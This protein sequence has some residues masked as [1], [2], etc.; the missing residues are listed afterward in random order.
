MDINTCYEAGKDFYSI[1]TYSHLVPIAI[2]LFLSIYILFKTKFS[3]QSI[4]FSLFSGF[5]CLW[6]AGDLITWTSTNY[7]LLVASWSQLD[8]INIIFFVLAA[9]FFVVTI[10]ERDVSIRHKIFLFLLTLPGFYST[11]LLQTAQNFDQAFCNVTNSNFLTQYKLIQEF[12]CIAYIIFIGYLEFVKD[13]ND[14]TKRS[15]IFYIGSAFSLFLG[16]FAVTEYLASEYGGIAYT[17][18]LYG[19]FIL[20]L[21]LLIVIFSIVR[22]QMFDLK[23]IG[24]QLLVYVLVIIVAT[25]FL[26]LEN[27]TNKIL[28]SITLFLAVSFAYMLIKSINQERNYLTQIEKLA[29]DLQIANDGQT[30]LIH[31][32]NHQIKGY[33][34]KSRN[35]FS[36]LLT[37]PLYGPVS[38]AAK[39]MMKEG[40]NSL[41]E[42]VDFVQQILNAS[43][44][45]KGTM[46]YFMQPFDMKKV[47]EEVTEKQRPL[48]EA[49]GLHFETIIDEGNFEINGDRAQLKEAVRNLIDNSI[50]YTIKGSVSVHLTNGAGKILLTVKDTGI[51]I[52]DEDK[53]RLF[54]KGGRGKNSIKINVNSSGYGLSFVKGVI[55][56][57]KGK[58]WCESDGQE[59]GSTFYAELPL[60]S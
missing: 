8:N 21:F 10:R 31:V 40:F 18:S 22:F 43:N 44:I 32:I 19:L 49:K 52:T 56:A 27:S 51:G 4:V 17:V 37:E 33:I 20:P 36:E 12:I 53:K 23:R 11:I 45:E 16:V 2:T 1:A 60:T 54:T 42:G 15:K 26:F 5:F 46:A 6:L 58:V 59:K 38:D 9:Y 47:V 7:D 50:N 35:I 30:N 41:T 24:T 28:N 48:A 25:Q 39:P 57:H 14:S 34:A 3:F 55:D 13:K 29:S